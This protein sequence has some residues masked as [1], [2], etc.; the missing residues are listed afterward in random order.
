M[1]AFTP[2]GAAM[3]PTYFTLRAPH[4]LR[5]SIVAT[6]EPPVASIGS[7][8][9]HTCAVAEDGSELRT[10]AQGVLPLLFEEIGERLAA[11]VEIGGAQLAGGA[12]GGEEDDG[13]GDEN[14]LLHP[15]SLQRAAAGDDQA[16]VAVGGDQQDAVLG[17]LPDRAH[18]VLRQRRPALQVEH[19]AEY[20]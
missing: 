6:D 20:E 16:S 4:R 19:G 13:E 7:R 1:R 5:I 15:L 9:R 14:Q 17:R 2:S 18:A 3:R 12:G 10:G 11:F 8:T